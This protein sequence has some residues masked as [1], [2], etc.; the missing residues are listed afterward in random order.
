MFID[1]L[2]DVLKKAG[3]SDAIVWKDKIYS[4][5]WLLDRIDYWN[6]EIESQDILPGQPVILEADFS[7]NSSA[8]LLALIEHRSIVIPLSSAININREEY[9]E[10][11]QAEV[12]IKID[13]S[14]RAQI[15]RTGK[16]ADHPLYRKL[17]EVRHPG[18]VLFSSGSTGKSKAAVHDFYKLLQKFKTRRHDLRTI[19]FLLFDHIGGL[20]TFFYSLSNGSCIITVDNRNPEAI[21]AAIEKYKAQVLPV[22]PTFLNLLILSEAYSRYDLSSLKYITYGTEVMPEATLKRC[23]EIFPNVTIL[24]KYGTTEVGTLRSKSK[25]SNSLWVKVGGEGY[26]TR[27]VDGILQIKADSAMLG[28]LNAPNP[29]TDDGWFITGD[30]V[31]QEGDYIRFLGRKSEIISVGGE[32]VFPAEVENVI[33]AFDNVAEAEVYGEKNRIVGNIICARVKL[34]VDEDH[35]AFIK[36]LKKYCLQILPNYKVPVKIEIVDDWHYS[37]R[38]KK[39]RSAPDKAP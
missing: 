6:D 7:P 20:D 32:K 35:K 33:K 37:A 4:Y 26:R 21:C 30:M 28:Y 38:Y 12:I 22:S 31:M 1:F 27:I 36:R 2:I 3:D 29:F 5:N 19:A 39:I 10:I 16:A 25:S 14:D 24:Q 9:V 23:A 18:L 11:S 34:K 13:D 15:T 17:K 8:L